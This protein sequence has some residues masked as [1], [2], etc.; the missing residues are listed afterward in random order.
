MRLARKSALLALR[1]LEPGPAGQHD[2][3]A[4]LVELDDLGLERL[5]D[6]RLQV[7]HPAQL[8]ERGGQEAAQ[9]D[10][11]DQAALDDLDDRAGHDSVFLLDALDVAPGPLVLGAFLDST[12]RPSL[13]SLVSTG[14]DLIAY[15]HDL[16][17]VDVVPDRQLAAGDHA[18]GLVADVEQ[19]LVAVGAHHRAGDHGAILDGHEGGVDGVGEAAG[20][21]VVDDLARVYPDS[22]LTSPSVAVAEA[23][24]VVWASDTNG[25]AFFGVGIGG[26]QG[27]A[28]DGTA[29]RA[30]N[31]ALQARVA[32]GPVEPLRARRHEQELG[33]VDRRRIGAVGPGSNRPDGLHVEPGSGRQQPELPGREARGPQVGRRRRPVLVADLGALVVDARAASKLSP[34]SSQR[35]WK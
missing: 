14:L 12:R 32:A 4:V 29:T 33:S 5:A 10:V 20:E 7:T 23:G 1:L 25:S 31:R 17:G 27:P 6:V 26:L 30:R 28:G 21:V 15:L 2:V 3:V 24:S 22:A 13:S 19:D 16:V 34:P 9:L 35:T 8:D 11:E 18:L